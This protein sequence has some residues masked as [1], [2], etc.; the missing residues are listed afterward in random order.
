MIASLSAS[1]KLDYLRLIRSENV[2][3]I[4]FYNLLKYFGSAQEALANVQDFA[5]RGGRTKPI[6]LCPASVAE[7]EI[8]ALQKIG[9]EL[10]AFNEPEYSP[11]LAEINDAPPLLSVL[12]FKN[13]MQK[14]AVGIVGTRDASINGRNMARKLGL[15]L[16]KADIVVVSGM[17]LGIDAAAHEG[18]LND[19]SGKGGTIAV[20]GTGI[21]IAYPQANSRLYQEIK[22]RGLLVSEFPFGT[23]PQQNNFPRRNRIISGLSVGVLVVEAKKKSGSLITANMALEQGREVYAI[24]GSPLDARSQ[25]GNHLLKLGAVLIESPSDVIDSVREEKIFTLH[26]NIISD[27][28]AYAPE[29]ISSGELDEAREKILRLLGNGPVSIDDLIRISEAGSALV[30]I[31]LVEL[32]LAGKL[33]R[34]AGNKV[35]LLAEWE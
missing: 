23:A 10:I 13:L 15:E 2:G 34:L 28:F 5:R 19:T 32:E 35:N 4:T 24:P 18:A 3:A 14:K 30:S 33:E 25:G 27:D 17:A 22:E 21:D 26:E 29:K 1:E 12:G 16:T 7:K 9:A 6:S 31:V 20:L 11:L 8:A